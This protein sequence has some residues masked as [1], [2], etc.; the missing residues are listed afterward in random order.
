MVMDNRTI[1][2]L[3][4]GALPAAVAI[5]R[6]SGSR[7]RFVF[8]MLTGKPPEPR[9]TILTAIRDP[10]SGDLLDTGLAVYFPQPASFTGEDV[11]EFHLHGG[12]AVVDGVL[13]VLSKLDGLRA[14]DPGEFTRRAFLNGK[15]DLTAAG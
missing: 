11:A 1:F 12:T 10:E 14:A 3:S 8:E 15:M 4:S 2:A 7:V 13:R 6:L 5:I 9:R